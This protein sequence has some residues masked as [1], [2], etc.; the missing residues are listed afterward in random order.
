MIPSAFRYERPATIKEALGFLA[1]P[2][3]KVLAGG[4]SL[5]P[6]LR[7]RMAEPGLLVD[8]QDIAEL[9]GMRLEAQSVRLGALLRHAELR[10]AAPW[11][12]LREAAEATGDR[13][14][15][16]LGTIGGATAH[17]DP[18][19]DLP[20]ALLAIGATVEIEGPNGRHEMPI[21]EFF[22]GPLTTALAADEIL[23]GLRLPLPAA[24]SGSSY[25]KLRQK[26]SGFAL[27]GVGAMVRLEEG[28]CVDAGIGVTGVGLAPYAA[29]AARDR[30]LGTPLAAGDIDA[31]LE[32]ILDGVDVQGDAY[33]SA[34]YR[35]SMCRLCALQAI[36]SARAEALG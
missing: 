33:A 30:L 2:E 25:R 20:A 5:L 4:Q 31:A 3:A 9:Q 11:R 34:D 19:G 15:R 23:T 36:E 29:D 18:A 27:A 13:Q 35:S 16:R 6:L 22:L 28:R 10:E 26:A 8:L 7:L 17:A 21:G 1:D 32:M 14:V 12:V 24:G